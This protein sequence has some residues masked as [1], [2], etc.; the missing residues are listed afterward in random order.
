MTRSQPGIRAAL[1]PAIIAIAFIAMLI[2]TWGGWPDPLV[3]FGRELYVPWQLSQGK[4][5]YRDLAYFNGPLSA[6]FNSILFRIL[7]VSLRTLVLANIAICIAM[8]VII[9]KIFRLAGDRFSATVAALLFIALFMT[10]Q[11]VAIGNYNWITPYSHELTHGIAL[12]FAAILALVA[13]FRRPSPLRAGLV[14][15][16]IGMIFLA[17][18][19][20]FIAIALPI[21]VAMIIARCRGRRSLLA[22]G[23]GALIPPIISIALL[24]LTMPMDRS[25]RG[26]LGGWAYVLNSR[27]SGLP[28]YRRGIGLDDASENLLAATMRLAGYLI[29]FAYGIALDR[30]FERRNLSRTIRITLAIVQAS[31]LTVGLYLFDVAW[32]NA[33]RGLPLLLICGFTILFARQQRRLR[34]KFIL[35]LVLIGFA[36]LLTL[37]MILSVRAYHYGFALAMPALLVSAALG[38]TWLPRTLGFRW[39]ISTRLAVTTALVLAA[40]AHLWIYANRFSHKPIIVAP[41]TADEFRADAMGQLVNEIVE[42]LKPL[43][44]DTT[45]AIV[46]QGVMINYLAGKANPTPFFTLMPPEVLMF[47]DDRIVTAYEKSRPDLI[48]VIPTDL[49]EYG[50]QKMDDYAPKTTAWFRANYQPIRSI[51]P[52]GLPPVT[53]LRRGTPTTAPR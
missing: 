22:F 24:S 27:V 16:L 36:F 18:P 8:V 53:I 6:Y 48:V 20:V 44:A 46:P 17:K 31:L 38:V 37:K 14:G 32:D 33:F 41:D 45:V 40:F 49:S 39:P 47:G 7:G 34:P 50:F 29:V 5:L 51:N 2:W 11:F 1:V 15:F 35:R 21:V 28:F 19:E 13:Y 23:V 42:T 30:E 26:T 52:P 43:P 25:F 9:W 3:D 4:V 12:S 10:T